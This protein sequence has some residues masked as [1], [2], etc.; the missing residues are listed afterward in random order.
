MLQ[1]SRELADLASVLATIIIILVIGVLIELVFFG[2]VERRMLKRR[3][4]S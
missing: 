3:G 1:Q 2:P 4:S